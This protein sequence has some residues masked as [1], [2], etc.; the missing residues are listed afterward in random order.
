MP[1]TEVTNQ[2]NIDQS[3]LSHMVQIND[4]MQV[5]L[6]QVSSRVQAL[7]QKVELSPSLYLL[8]SLCD[9]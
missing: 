9:A 8:Q 4:K 7:E 5:D 6:Q 2:L 3:M 1:M